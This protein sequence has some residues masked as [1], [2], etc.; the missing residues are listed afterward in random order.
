M[1]VMVQ[2]LSAGVKNFQDHLYKRDFLIERANWLRTQ[3]GDRILPISLIGK[4]GWVDY[5]G[6]GNIDDFQK[7]KPFTNKKDL[8]KRLRALNQYLKSQDIT[9]LIVVAPNKATIYPDKLPEQIKSL[10]TPSRLDQLMTSLEARNLHI[11]V[12]LRPSLSAARGNQDVYFKENNTHWNGYGAFVAYTTII[13]RLK[14]SYPG[15]EPYNTSELKR[16]AAPPNAVAPDSYFVPEHAF[17]RTLYFGNNIDPN[18][19][20]GTDYGYHQFSSIANSKLPILL[21][22]H[23]SFGAFYLNDY[24][25]MNFAE[26]HFVHLRD[27]PQYLSQEAILQ[28]KPDVVMIQIVERNLDLLINTLTNFDPNKGP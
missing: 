21:M 10:P 25:S 8:L 3:L 27:A 1:Y 9:L 26:S 18:R 15:L 20:W 12:D 13:N 23:D 16:V 17:V 22:F 19:I 14:N 24:L 5:T 6:D 2:S 28:F 4:D 7:L 11:L